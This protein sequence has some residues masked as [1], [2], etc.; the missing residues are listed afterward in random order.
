MPTLSKGDRSFPSPGL[1]LLARSRC[2]DDDGLPRLRLDDGKEE[3]KVGE[4]RYVSGYAGFRL[5]SGVDWPLDAAEMG[6]VDNGWLWRPKCSC[7][8]K[9]SCATPLDRREAASS[10]SSFLPMLLLLSRYPGPG[11]DGLE[12]MIWSALTSSDCRL[13]D[14]EDAATFAYCR[15]RGDGPAVMMMLTL[16]RLLEALLL[17][18][19]TRAF[20]RDSNIET[21]STRRESA[22]RRHWPQTETLFMLLHL[23]LLRM[24]A[25]SSS[26]V[27]RLSSCIA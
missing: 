12:R 19:S 20:Q 24:I 16:Q 23:L 14:V 15:G 8:P 11:E 22:A 2:I 21:S 3:D 1:L 7:S 26:W 13:I 27:H 18:S 9:P 25:S 17:N 10:S 4:P 5:S 6:V